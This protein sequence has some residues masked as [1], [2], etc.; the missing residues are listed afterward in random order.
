MWDYSK[1]AALCFCVYAQ[2][3]E[4]IAFRVIDRFNAQ[5]Y[6]PIHTHEITNQLSRT[7]RDVWPTFY[8]VLP[9]DSALFFMRFPTL[10]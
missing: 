6:R 10:G 7:I 8:F 3:Y 5:W 9:F 2:P 4:Q 1:H